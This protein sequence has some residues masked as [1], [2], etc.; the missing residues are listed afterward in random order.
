MLSYVLQLTSGHRT[1]ILCAMEKIVK[2]KMD[3]IDSDLTMAT[4]KQASAELTLSK[5]MAIYL[6][7]VIIC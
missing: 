6:L 2:Q 5:V 3:E 4:I 1:V 7:C